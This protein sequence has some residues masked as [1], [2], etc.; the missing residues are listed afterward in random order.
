MISRCGFIIMQYCSTAVPVLEVQQTSSLGFGI[1]W[2]CTVAG[3]HPNGSSGSYSGACRCN[4]PVQVAPQ[5]AEASG[6][7]TDTEQRAG[8][9]QGRVPMHE[10]AYL[11]TL[12][13]R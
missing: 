11:R 5:Q 13:V 12:L 6:L 7:T 10:N 8:Q 9:L 4:Q 2:L 3:S 1:Q